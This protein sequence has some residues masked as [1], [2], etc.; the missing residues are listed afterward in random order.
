MPEPEWCCSGLIVFSVGKAVPE[1]EWEALIQQ[2]LHAYVLTA[3][4]I[5][6]RVRSRPIYGCSFRVVLPALPE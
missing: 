5:L 6:F 3:R 2:N 1:I 4:P